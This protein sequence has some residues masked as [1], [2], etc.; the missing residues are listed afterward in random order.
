[1]NC[2]LVL[3]HSLALG[4][5]VSGSGACPEFWLKRPSLNP[6]PQGHSEGDGAT[7]LIERIETMFGFDFSPQVAAIYEMHPFTT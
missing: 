6:F 4:V 3:D 5:S 7:F 1:V 2:K